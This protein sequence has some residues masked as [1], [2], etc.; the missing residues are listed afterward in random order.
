MYTQDVTKDVR[1]WQ[2]NNS[3]VAFI[4]PSSELVPLNSTSFKASLINSLTAVVKFKP[5]LSISK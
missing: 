5:Y 1:S 3:V 4:I 2:G